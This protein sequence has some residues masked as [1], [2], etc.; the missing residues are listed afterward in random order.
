M[1]TP[2]RPN[3]RNDYVRGLQIRFATGWRDENSARVT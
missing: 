1:T 2:S 3:P